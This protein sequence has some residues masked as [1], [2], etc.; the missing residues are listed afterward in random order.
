M[1][2][3]KAQKNY[4]KL[5]TNFYRENMTTY[6]VSI[7][8]ACMN[9]HENLI[10]CL[11]GW[12]TLPVEQIIIVDWSSDQSVRNIIRSRY[13]TDRIVVITVKNQQYWH[14]TKAFNLA[15]SACK[16]S[17][18]LKLDCDYFCSE[19]LIKELYFGRNS[20]CHI[21]HENLKGENKFLSGLFAAD[22][23]LLRKVNFFDERIRSY[24][25]DETDLFRRVYWHA[26]KILK[27]NSK[28]VSHLPHTE[29]QRTESSENSLAGIIAS[30][31][32]VSLPIVST[33]LNRYATEKREEWSCAFASNT[34]LEK[35]I[36]MDIEIT[37]RTQ[38][39][40]YY[41]YFDYSLIH[42][43]VVHCD[44]LNKSNDSKNSGKIASKIYYQWRHYLSC[45]SSEGNTLEYNKELLP[46]NPKDDW[47]ILE[48]YLDRR[49]KTSQ[50]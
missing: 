19:N 27:V 2:K 24:G 1:L 45:I 22:L 49:R 23:N 39:E 6:T 38:S 50:K 10:Q 18:I 21:R 40:E 20:F 17:H 16:S 4:S 43:T 9:R 30:K 33:L 12:L 25:W 26:E 11:P 37:L 8:T 5:D 14:L 31:C 28:S 47:N 3:M 41:S 35:P 48:N 36:S 32:Q 15:L 44:K 42:S 13:T 29:D 7:A 34:I 46:M